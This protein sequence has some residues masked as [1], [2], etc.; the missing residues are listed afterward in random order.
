[1][2]HRYLDEKDGGGA[3]Q[4]CFALVHGGLGQPRWRTM[5]KHAQEGCGGGFCKVHE[6]ESKGEKRK[7]ERE[8]RNEKGNIDI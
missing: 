5:V 4:Q 7:G 6:N 8:R 3:R 2:V 1:M